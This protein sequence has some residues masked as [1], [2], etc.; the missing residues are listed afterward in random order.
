[1]KNCAEAGPAIPTN[2]A[3]AT[4]SATSGPLSV[5]MRKKDFVGFGI[6]SVANECQAIAIIADLG[7]KRA[8]VNP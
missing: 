8:A 2:S 1:L 5:K 3:I 7:R 6:R 4:V